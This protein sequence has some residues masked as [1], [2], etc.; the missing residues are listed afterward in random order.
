[1]T[2]SLAKALTSFLQVVGVSCAKP[3]PQMPLKSGRLCADGEPGSIAQ[4]ATAITAAPK[5]A[6]VRFM[7]TSV[8][9]SI[10][11]CRSLVCLRRFAVLLLREADL[12][13]L[14][15]GEGE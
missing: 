9:S 11:A 6:Y 1:S 3:P 7:R 8:A 14:A 15:V 10:R 5:I 12:D 13:V 4:M 2:L